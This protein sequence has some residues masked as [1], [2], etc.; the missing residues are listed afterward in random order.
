LSHATQAR[1]PASEERISWQKVEK[2]LSEEKGFPSVL[3]VTTE[4]LTMLD[5]SD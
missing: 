5:S 4:K 2:L 3:T 1:R